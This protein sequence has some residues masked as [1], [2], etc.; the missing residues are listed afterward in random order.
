M[1]GFFH[2]ETPNWDFP[3]EEENQWNIPFL[4]KHLLQKLW[5]L[6]FC[7]TL[8]AARFHWELATVKP[9]GAIYD[10]NTKNIKNKSISL[11]LLLQLETQNPLKST[12]GHQPQSNPGI[13]ILI[14]ELINKKFGFNVQ[15]RLDG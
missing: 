14:L 8:I 2:W 9:R 3:L 5:H 1:F 10:F 12:S 13:P 6:K 15:D 7:V 11:H 4:S